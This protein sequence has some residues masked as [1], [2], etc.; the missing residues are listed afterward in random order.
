MKNPYVYVGIAQEVKSDLIINMIKTEFDVTF[1]Q[2]ESKSRKRE[3]VWARQS[4]M[5]LIS[6]HTEMILSDIGQ[7]F[8]RD[9]ST[10]S[11]AKN[12]V[13]SWI[14]LK[15]EPIESVNTLDLKL[16]NIKDLNNKVREQ[17]FE[18]SIND[19]P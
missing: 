9:H 17:Q 16:E 18:E 19:Q 8:N 5:Y 2:L 12:T 4:A 7:C 6:R 3:I 14:Q 15:M 13:M 10:V 11:H 1:E